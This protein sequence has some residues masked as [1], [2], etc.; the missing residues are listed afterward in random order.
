MR[1]V[2]AIFF[3]ILFVSACSLMDYNS[4]KERV[5]ELLDKYKN[6]D[7][8]ILNELDNVISNEYSGEY[9]DR[10]KKLML[11]QY[12]NMEYKITDEIID[13]ST[14][15]VTT[16]ITV[17]NYGSMIET[18]NEYL[19]QHEEEFYSDNEEEKVVDNDKFLDYKLNLLEEVED[20]KTYTVEF[21]LTKENKEWKLDNLSDTN[22][23]KI[24]GIYIE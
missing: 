4:P 10:Y 23:S 13:G 20:R 19:K 24:H 9:K 3:V 21:T 12:K 17:Y 14:A 1:K 6:Q 5:K 18:A 22:I 8:A 15:V 11:N 7:S 16:D 2:L